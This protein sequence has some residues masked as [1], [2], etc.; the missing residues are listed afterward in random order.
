M[1]TKKDL[2]EKIKELEAKLKQ[3]QEKLEKVERDFRT[4]KAI[5]SGMIGVNAKRNLKA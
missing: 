4:Y 2:L 5:K 3:T 1:E